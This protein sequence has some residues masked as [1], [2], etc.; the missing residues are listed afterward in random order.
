MRRMMADP[1]LGL[2]N[3]LHPACGSCVCVCVSRG[4]QHGVGETWPASR[5]GTIKLPVIY[6]FLWSRLLNLR[7][8]GSSA[9]PH[10]CRALPGGLNHGEDELA[11]GRRAGW[12]PPVAA[13]RSRHSH[14]RLLSPLWSSEGLFVFCC[15]VWRHSVGQGS[16][17]AGVIRVPAAMCALA[18]NGWLASHVG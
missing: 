15:P 11:V 2:R 6:P 8:E 9:M 17:D 7:V 14:W 5:R 18:F 1:V 16:R 10:D 4:E 13:L 3:L 12:G